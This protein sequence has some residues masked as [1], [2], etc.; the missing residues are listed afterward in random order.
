MASRRIATLITALTAAALLPA[1][2][3]G[4]QDEPLGQPAGW[5]VEEPVTLVGVVSGSELFREPDPATMV[6]AILP[7]AQLPLIETRGTWVKVRYGDQVGWVDLEGG[8]RLADAAPRGDARLP[9]PEPGP[10]RPP[11]TISAAV[12][13]G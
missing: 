10:R 2:T 8:R 13:N 1:A 5:A 3:A 12:S 7:E 11:P 9:V 6:L 4:A